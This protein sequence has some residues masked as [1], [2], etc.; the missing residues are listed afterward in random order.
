[1][2]PS[3]RRRQIE[4][5]PPPIDWLVYGKR[6]DRSKRCFVGDY[7]VLASSTGAPPSVSTVT[8]L[9]RALHP[10]LLRTQCSIAH[11]G[12]MGNGDNTSTVVV[13]RR[14]REVARDPGGNPARQF[15]E[16]WAG[17]IVHP[18]PDKGRVPWGRLLR[19][20]LERA[21][22]DLD[23]CSSEPKQDLPPLQL[24]RS[25][26]PVAMVNNLETRLLVSDLCNECL[27]GRPR[28]VEVSSWSFDTRVES[29][30][31]ILEA[32]PRAFRH[33]TTL[34]SYITYPQGNPFRQSKPI[35][36]AVTDKSEPFSRALSMAGER[37]LVAANRIDYLSQFTNGNAQLAAAAYQLLRYQLTKYRDFGVSDTSIEY[38]P[39]PDIN[40]LND[41]LAKNVAQCSERLCFSIVRSINHSKG[42]DRLATPAQI[43]WAPGALF[44]V[45]KYMATNHRYKRELARLSLPRDLESEATQNTK[46]VTRALQEPAEEFPQKPVKLPDTSLSTPDAS[47]PNISDTTQNSKS[48]AS[49][50]QEPAQEFSQKPAELPDTIL[51]SPNASIV[52]IL[53]T[54]QMADAKAESGVSERDQQ[55]FLARWFGRRDKKSG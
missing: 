18:D 34:A 4:I 33:K 45:A 32:L 2:V 52:D 43:N 42:D 49:A 40:A 9:L 31:Y 28:T 5:D 3:Q 1:M 24:R 15:I 26:C 19:A 23:I 6:F 11:L 12:S 14:G 53:D 13:Y 44:R 54:T 48:V 41:A 55:G 10:D 7:E 37:F 29:I 27:A 38:D 8:L 20:L 46:S 36:F 50:F 21:E 39:A 51:S 35:C 17:R 22:K 30:G 47:I 16:A 25:N